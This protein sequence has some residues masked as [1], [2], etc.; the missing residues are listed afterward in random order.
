MEKNYERLRTSARKR[1]VVFLLTCCLVC[2][3]TILCASIYGQKR[4]DIV[5]NDILLVD[6]LKYID[7]QTEYAVLYRSDQL[8]KIKL[9]SVSFKDATVDEVLSFCL[10]NTGFSYQIN[11]NTIVLSKRVGQKDVLPQQKVISNIRGT[12]LDQK[13]DPLPGATVIIKG[14][15]IGTVTNTDGKFK[16]KVP[17]DMKTLLVS[18]VGYKSKDVQLGVADSVTVVLEEVVVAMADVVV[19]GFF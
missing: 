1:V 9:K 19:T 11:E 4:L 3:H 12:V 7:T 8:N 18:F 2:T 17:E 6:V 10:R 14:T 16:L 5:L 13:K 15:T